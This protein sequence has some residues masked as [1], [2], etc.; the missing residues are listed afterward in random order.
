MVGP[1]IS[2]TADSSLNSYPGVDR[3]PLS[4]FGN[5]H[6]ITRR[7]CFRQDESPVSSAVDRGGLRVTGRH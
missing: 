3:P 2:F 7:R 1:P 5:L 4:V 6:K